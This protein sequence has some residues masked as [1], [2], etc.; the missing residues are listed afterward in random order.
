[1]KK[2]NAEM[3]LCSFQRSFFM[4][5]KTLLLINYSIKEMHILKNKYVTTFHSLGEYYLL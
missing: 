4:K 2:K 5:K 3:F 1:M